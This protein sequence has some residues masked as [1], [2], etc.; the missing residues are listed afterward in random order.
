MVDE[1]PDDLLVDDRWWSFLQVKTYVKRVKRIKIR[2][3]PKRTN[4][5]IAGNN[6]ICIRMNKQ[7]TKEKK[8]K[9]KNV[10]AFIMAC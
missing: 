2:P 7:R 6:D 4:E 9:K 1:F 5:M 10:R 3:K 8:N